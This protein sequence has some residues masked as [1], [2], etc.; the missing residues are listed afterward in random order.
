M[1]VAEDVGVQRARVS[2]GGSERELLATRARTVGVG[3]LL[4][5]TT[6]LSGPGEMQVFEQARVIY[7]FRDY[8]VIL[9][10]CTT[11][12]LTPIPPTLYPLPPTPYPL[13]PNTNTPYP[14]PP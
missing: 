13:P 5:G 7:S 14:L 1:V 2:R 12:Y 11:P 6:S 8:D 3:V 9:K 10:I 4:G